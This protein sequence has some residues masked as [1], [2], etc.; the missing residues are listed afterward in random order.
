MKKK[1][2][3][4]KSPEAIL[5]LENWPNPGKMQERKSARILLLFSFSLSLS[6][7]IMFYY[8]IIIIF[9]SNKKDVMLGASPNA[10]F[11][12]IAFV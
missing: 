8:T 12:I 9:L 7:Q 11:F 1:T 5:F 4:K 6:I 3:K 10:T 2:K